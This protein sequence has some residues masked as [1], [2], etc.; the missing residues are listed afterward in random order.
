MTLKMSFGRIILYHIR[1]IDLFYNSGIIEE[2]K[3]EIKRLCFAPDHS[4]MQWFSLC[5][6]D[7]HQAKS[8]PDTELDYQTNDAK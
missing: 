5:L 3:Q 8:P 2:N 6:S 1:I 7:L 4:A